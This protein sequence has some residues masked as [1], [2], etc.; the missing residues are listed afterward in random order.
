M[1]GK[2]G[3]RFVMTDDCIL[4]I[5]GD[6][7]TFIEGEHAFALKLSDN[8][9]RI[10]NRLLQSRHEQVSYS[11]LYKE[12]GKEKEEDGLVPSE[13][14]SK[15]KGTMDPKIRP[16][17]KAW[18]N[19]T[20][21][22]RG[23]HI[24]DVKTIEELTLGV[25]SE[26]VVPMFSKGTSVTD[27]GDK[28]PSELIDMTGDYLAFYIN[29]DAHPAENHL[30]GAYIR[31]ECSD[32]RLIAY[33]VLGVHTNE[34]LIRISNLFDNETACAE[35]Y[36]EIR[37]AYRNRWFI[38]TLQKS[39]DYIAVI[40]LTS[41]IDNDRWNIVLDIKDFVCDTTRDH[42]EDK[43]KYRAGLGLLL[44]GWSDWG[45]AAFRIAV[46]RKIW[47]DSQTMGMN[48]CGIKD[49]LVTENYVNTTRE[50]DQKF[51]RWVLNNGPDFSS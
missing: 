47:F 25:Q 14:L 18:Y 2:L 50:L 9:K 38:G 29:P 42:I 51:Y 13:A 17:I 8:H 32:N 12:Y 22:K 23:Y 15:M 3:K 39:S 4:Q 26:S 36:K 40:T 48:S 46:I 21:K 34:E 20:T 16:Y 45:L 37:R 28:I 35:K 5:I 27:I 6:D 43:D 41:G 33:A 49:W 7:F 31:I 10:L 1:E 24:P 19:K 44:A 30:L 11:D